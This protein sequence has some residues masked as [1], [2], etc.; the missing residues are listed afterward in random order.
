MPYQKLGCVC[1]I[2]FDA[3]KVK[4]ILVV[5]NWSNKELSGVYVPD[6][7]VLLVVLTNKGVD[8]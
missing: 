2:I 3:V 8:I 4:L 7:V 6:M 5:L 1:S